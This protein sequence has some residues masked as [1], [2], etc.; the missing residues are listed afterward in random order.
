[1]H[2]LIRSAAALTGAAALALSLTACGDDEPD[3]TTSSE[4]SETSEETSTS[5]D[6]T[7]TDVTETPTDTA[8]ESDTATD[9]A[10][11]APTDSPVDPGDY[12]TDAATQEF[13]DAFNGSFEVLQ[14]TDQS[15]IPSE[16]D[17]ALFVAELEK[18]GAIGTPA[19]I[20]A[21]ERRGFE[22]Y[23][24]ALTTLDYQVLVDNKDSDTLPGV[25]EED[26]AAAEAFSEWAFSTCLEL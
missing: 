14:D 12:P 3:D 9:T 7:E 23:I 22:V 18:L 5:T 25:S 6:V 17:W 26:N 8:T 19:D 4:S 20:G 1:M 15:G 10:T 21:E 24:G 11:D 16:D 13:C 2:R